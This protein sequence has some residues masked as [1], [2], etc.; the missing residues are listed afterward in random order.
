[1]C[2]A[3]QIV[4]SVDSCKMGS[5]VWYAELLKWEGADS[6]HGPYRQRG[7]TSGL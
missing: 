2:L 4:V 1:M 7:A 6:A 5:S 3:L